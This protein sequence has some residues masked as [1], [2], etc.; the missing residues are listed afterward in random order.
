MYATSAEVALSAPARQ[1]GLLQTVALWVGRSR[2]RRALA[3][4][5]ATELK[6]IGLDLADATVEAAKPFW[7]A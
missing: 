2:Q 5:S 4:L 1:V 3:A 7:V 6:D